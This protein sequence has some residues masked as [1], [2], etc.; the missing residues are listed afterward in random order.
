MQKL[1]RNMIEK[2]YPISKPQIKMILEKE[3]WGVEMLKKV[4]LDTIV[5]RLNMKDVKIGLPRWASSKLSL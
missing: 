2:S 5:N 1:F 4:S 3:D